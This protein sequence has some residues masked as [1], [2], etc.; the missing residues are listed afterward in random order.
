[1]SERAREPVGGSGSRARSLYLPSEHDHMLSVKEVSTIGSICYYRYATERTPGRWGRCGRAAPRGAAGGRRRRH[2]SRPRPT[3]SE[4]SSR[5]SPSTFASSKPS[6][7]CSCSSGTGGAR[8]RPSS[9]PA[10][11]NGPGGAQRDRSAARGPVDAPGSRDRACDPRRG[12]HREPRGSFR[13]LVAEI[14]ARRAR[15]SLRLTEGASERLAADVAT[16]E[17]ASAIVTEPVS[18]PRLHVEHLATKSSS[19]WCR[20]RRKSVPGRRSHLPCSPTSR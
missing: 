7:A 2:V 20:R 5:T 12:W 8:C 15:V 19:R 9:A 10:S 1:M 4:R 18:D 13:V 17:L 11:S 16:R 14:R 3:A 6:S